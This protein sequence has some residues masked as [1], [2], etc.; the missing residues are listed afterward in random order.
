MSACA[1]FASIGTITAG[2]CLTAVALTAKHNPCGKGYN[3]YGI[4][5][6]L[7]IHINRDRLKLATFTYH[8]G[9]IDDYRTTKFYWSDLRTEHTRRYHYKDRSIFKLRG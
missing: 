9:C 6:D 3:F 1:W 7:Y 8:T 2:S 4:P 5:L